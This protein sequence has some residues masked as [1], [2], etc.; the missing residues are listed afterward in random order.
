MP[1]SISNQKA[2]YIY[3]ALRF[4]LLVA[5]TTFVLY[6]LLHRW[7]N[8]Q[9]GNW[10]PLTGQWLFPILV[11]DIIFT[12]T[13]FAIDQEDKI[14]KVTYSLR[15]YSH[16]LLWWARKK[17]TVV[18]SIPFEEFNG[19]EIGFK[20]KGLKKYLI[21][22][23]NTEGVILKSASIPLPLLSIKSYTHLIIQLDKLT[24]QIKIM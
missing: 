13:Y 14:I 3:L 20:L 9:V 21:L 15:P 6:F 22:Y 18:L 24:H 2:F 19:Y 16:L 11:L 23:K 10:L 7:L 12:P 8:L 17:P 5:V 1:L 4:V